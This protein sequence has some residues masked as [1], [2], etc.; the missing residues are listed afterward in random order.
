M[1]YYQEFQRFIGTVNCPKPEEQVSVMQSGY[2]AWHE[3]HMKQ[4]RACEAAGDL[5]KAEEIYCT[6]TVGRETLWS[7]L[8]CV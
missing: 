6:L 8:E 2:A 7:R 3:Q 5:A 1:N 4:I